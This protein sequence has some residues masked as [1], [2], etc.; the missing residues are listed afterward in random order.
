MSLPFI[1]SSA[2]VSMYGR[3]IVNTLGMSWVSRKYLELLFEL[4]FEEVSELVGE[5]HS[6][7]LLLAGVL[8]YLVIGLHLAAVLLSKVLYSVSESLLELGEELGALGIAFVLEVEKNTQ[9]EDVEAR[10]SWVID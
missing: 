1:A 10:H 9:L 3:Y 4:L 2:M 5:E 7:P 8:D 6:Y